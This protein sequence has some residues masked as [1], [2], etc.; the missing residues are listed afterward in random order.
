M[1]I[2]MNADD[3]EYLIHISNREKN[4]VIDQLKKYP[5]NLELSSMQK[6]LKKDLESKNYKLL[7][8]RAVF[9]LI[10]LKKVYSS[11]SEIEA[12]LLEIIENLLGP[13]KNNL[14]K[15]AAEFW[16]DCTSV[17]DRKNFKDFSV[18]LVSLLI[19]YTF[20]SSDQKIRQFYE[21]SVLP[22][23]QN[24]IL[25]QDQTLRV[26]GALLKNSKDLSL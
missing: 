13:L 8:K 17:I 11:Q 7:I 23:L 16:D 24:L 26:I 14:L 10:H 20:K 21:E 22:A 1:I 5:M 4:L 6:A 3:N 19:E 2:G 9:Y 25:N 18:T 12:H 15:I